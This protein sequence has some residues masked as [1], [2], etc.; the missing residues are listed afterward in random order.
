MED[1]YLRIEMV[2]LAI[3][4]LVTNRD[5]EFLRSTSEQVIITSRLCCS[6]RD[7]R[8]AIIEEVNG[9]EFIEKLRSSGRLKFVPVIIRFNNGLTRYLYHTYDDMME[10]LDKF[11]GVDTNVLKW[12]SYNVFTKE[13]NK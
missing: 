5:I 3:N 1:E 9:D 13:M 12:K 7:L 11:M 8:N 4:S 2:A 6:L 10:A